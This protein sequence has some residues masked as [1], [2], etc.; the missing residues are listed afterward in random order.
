MYTL[1]LL[2]EVHEGLEVGNELGLKLLGPLLLYMGDMMQLCDSMTVLGGEG[3]RIWTDLKS[4]YLSLESFR[5]L[6]KVLLS[7]FNLALPL[8]TRV[9]E[10]G[11][12]GGGDVLHIEVA[13]RVLA[14]KFSISSPP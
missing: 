7:L 2:L 9:G 8:H 12:G 13:D 6:I 1:Y 4:L 5:D 14:I 10:N 11:G 3:G